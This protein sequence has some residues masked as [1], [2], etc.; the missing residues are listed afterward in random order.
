MRGR[1][2][3]KPQDVVILLKVYLNEGKLWTMQN[4]A[5]EL[6]MSLSEISYGLERLR[7]SGLINSS[8]K[9]VFKRSALEFLLYGFKYVFPAQLGPIHKGV[10][11]AHSAPPISKK[12]LSTDSMKFIWPSS[13]GTIYGQSIAPLYKTAPMAALRDERLYKALAVLDSLRIGRGREIVMA[14]EYLKKLFDGQP[15]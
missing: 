7:I 8:K 15:R 12:I 13:E 1:I 9:K 10:P 4:M 14:Q 11:T 2:F 3:L 5:S 6:F